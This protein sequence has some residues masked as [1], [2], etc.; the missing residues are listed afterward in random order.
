MNDIK[1]KVLEIQKLA[2]TP[3][4]PPPPP[5]K[6]KGAPTGK[7]P[8]GTGTGSP[9][10][11]GPTGGKFGPP[12]GATGKPAP[13]GGGGGGSYISSAAS[14]KE[15]QK[16]IQNF[17]KVATGYKTKMVQGPPAKPGG[18][19][20][21]VEKMDGED[22]RK[23]FNDFV[24]EQ[25]TNG[26]GIHGVEFDPSEGA[27]TKD[28]KKPTDNIEMDNVI[29]GLRRIG[30]PKPG[31]KIPDGIWDFRTQ[32][33]VMQ[34]Y[35]L[36]DAMVQITAFMSAPPQKAKNN[37]TSS[38]LSKFAANIPKTKE[39]PATSKSNVFLQKM[40]QEDLKNKAE[41]ITELVD[42][43]SYF[44][45]YYSKY[46]VDHPAYKAAINKKTPLI[47]AKNGGEDR[48][49]IKPEYEEVKKQLGNRFMT[50]VD[51]PYKNG[52]KISW[53]KAD[54]LS[55][56]VLQDVQSFRAFMLNTL[57]YSET[58]INTPE[59]QA[60]VLGAFDK[61]IRNVLSSEP[62]ALPPQPKAVTSDSVPA[63]KPNMA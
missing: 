36:A 40:S 25:Y 7:I 4:P 26:S 12:P 55:L 35:A 51:L 53:Y 5:P 37:F 52:D 63:V 48:G 31:E 18:K 45:E 57:K 9:P 61:H 32:N 21:V 14:V 56:S 44:Y 42:K 2:E 27:T 60:S 23:D 16:S 11:G 39:Y 20:T 47:T 10:P 33:A 54:K 38:D 58:D 15:M 1:K 46:V 43:L 6:F 50:N 24:S 62:I 3:A 29:D 30:S 22:S 19:P 34:T 8:G 41:V 13:T 59:V 17:A 28:E 49:V